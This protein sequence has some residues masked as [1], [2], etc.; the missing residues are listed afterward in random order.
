MTV[1]MAVTTTN[2]DDRLSDLP[3]W[4]SIFALVPAIMTMLGTLI[5]GNP[6]LLFSALLFTGVS[7]YSHRIQSTERWLFSI[8]AGMVWLRFITPSS[9]S[10]KAWL[11]VFILLVGVLA[12]AFSLKWNWRK[13][14]EGWSFIIFLFV[15]SACFHE[16]KSN[17]DNSAGEKASLNTTTK[18]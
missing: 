15:F 3:E 7:I 9:F 14:V 8:V 6:L 4:V 13:K 1:A 2:E 10:Q 17:M 12:K 11:M 18:P 16:T 5:P